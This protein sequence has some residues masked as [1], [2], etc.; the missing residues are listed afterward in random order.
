M[1][2]KG[3]DVRSHK[4]LR[5]RR[6]GL[7]SLFGTGQ[8]RSISDRRIRSLCYLSAFFGFLKPTWKRNGDTRL[9]GT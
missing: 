6:V 3:R 2:V 4:L 5:T 7:C 1:Q 9:P 8:D